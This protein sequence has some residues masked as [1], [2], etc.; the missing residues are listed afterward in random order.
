MSP[1]RS[2]IV[3]EYVQS[4]QVMTLDQVVFVTR[5]RTGNGVTSRTDIIIDAEGPRLIDERIVATYN[6]STLGNAND[7]QAT[8]IRAVRIFENF[9]AH[10]HEDHANIV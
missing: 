3:P 7:H 5:F 6:F 8:G 1:G 4:I 10:L 9:L 2:E